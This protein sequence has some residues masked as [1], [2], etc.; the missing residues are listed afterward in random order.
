MSFGCINH[1]FGCWSNLFL[2]GVKEK[3][4]LASKSEFYGGLL[5]NFFV[6]AKVWKSVR[7]RIVMIMNYSPFH[8]LFSN[9]SD[10]YGKQ[11][12]VYHS[13]VTFLRFSDSTLTMWSI[14]L[15][16]QATICFDPILPRTT[17]VGF[18]L[19]WK[20]YAVNC[21]FFFVFSYA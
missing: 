16:K 2:E 5:I 11:M 14:A 21:C 3:M 15:M 20:T 9:F 10:N 1:H 12:F 18:G 13:S 7:S 8:L 6:L 17:F 4:P 19:S